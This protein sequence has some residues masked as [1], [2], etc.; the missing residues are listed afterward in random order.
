[1]E[2]FAAI[3]LAC[4][5]AM[6]SGGG[7]GPANGSTFPPN[8]Q[9]DSARL[10]PQ[11]EYDQ[12]LAAFEKASKDYDRARF[13]AGAPKFYGS[14]PWAAPVAIG[15][16]LLGHLSATRAQTA[17]L[18]ATER[19]EQAE[20]RLLAAQWAPTPTPTPAASAVPD[21][22]GPPISPADPPPASL[23]PV[24]NHPCP[25]CGAGNTWQGRREMV[26]CSSC[27]KEFRVRYAK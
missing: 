3:C 20:D 8:A 24:F 12:A 26:T 4:T 21:P 25:Y 16:G 6:L 14:G 17:L 23:E 5:A 19:L 9:G 15:V 11:E 10:T 7:C 1:M 27:K 22:L 2:R 13:F 18:K